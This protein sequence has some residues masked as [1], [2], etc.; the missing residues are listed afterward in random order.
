VVATRELGALEAGV[1]DVRLA[2]RTRPAAGMYWVR[3]TQAGRTSKAVR[4][5]VLD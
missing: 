4:V 2:W 1:H 5:A 3:A